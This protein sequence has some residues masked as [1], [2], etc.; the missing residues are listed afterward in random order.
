MFCL[1]HCFGAPASVPGHGVRHWVFG[2]GLFR[3]GVF[4]VVVALCVPNAMAG[5]TTGDAAPG[6]DVLLRC[7]GPRNGQE[8]TEPVESVARVCGHHPLSVVVFSH[9][10]FALSISRGV[11][12]SG[13]QKLQQTHCSHLV[14]K[15]HTCEIEQKK[16][17]IEKTIRYTTY[18]TTLHM[19][20]I[21]FLF[22]VLPPSSRRP[23]GAK[24]VAISANIFLF[25]AHHHYSYHVSIF[26]TPSILQSSIS[27]LVFGFIS[28]LLCQFRR[29]YTVL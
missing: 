24:S 1:L 27:L 14:I 29:I 26:L 21:Y 9:Y 4:G 15:Q 8:P 10:L 22:V 12:L 17:S 5:A 25:M 18:Y 11:P 7:P 13:Q 20:L 23:A 2:G 16:Y 19:F 28:S 6:L 3:L